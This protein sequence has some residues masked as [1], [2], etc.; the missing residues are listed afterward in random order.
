MSL[1]NGPGE[2]GVVDS[3]SDGSGPQRP[4]V[5]A[6]DHAAEVAPTTRGAALNR[7]KRHGR[8]RWRLTAAL[9]IA[10]VAVAALTVVVASRNDIPSRTEVLGVD[11]GGLSESAAER[12]L[13]ERLA[14]RLDAAVPVRV[15]SAT[16]TIKPTD[17]GL[18]LD[19]EAT[20]DAAAGTRW[21]SLTGLFR[22]RDVAPVVRVD[23]DKLHTA[24]QRHV[25][26][27]GVSWTPPAI[28]YQDLTPVPVY[29]APGRG[30]DR[31][32]AAQTLR[33]A[34]LRRDVIDFSIVQVAPATDRSQVDQLINE[35]AGPAVSAPVLLAVGGKEIEITPSAIAQ[36]LQFESDESGRINPQFVDT[37]LRQS[38][39]GA[40][41]GVETPA[42][43]ATITLQ[44][45][46][47][48]VTPHVDGQAV[49]MAKLSADLLG[50]VRLPAPRRVTANV[51]PSAPAITTEAASGFGVKEK[52]SSFTTNFTAGQ[53]RNTNIKK[54]A[55]IVRGTLVKAGET[56]SLNAATGERTIAKGYVP[57]P[58]I[59]GSGKLKNAAGGG[60]SQFATTI[61]NAAYYAGLE[62]VEH[63]PHT[64]YFSRY[65]SVIEATTVYPSLDL[66]F[67]NDSPHAVLID[68]SYTATSLTVS[69]WSTK[70]YDIE[71]VY[72]PRT[73]VVAPNTVYL[74]EE[75]C[76][77]TAGIP[78][79]AQEAWRVFKQNG[80]EIKRQ[81]FFWRY[82]AEPRFVCGPPP[83]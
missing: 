18:V 50:A 29:P 7:I 81:R 19:V 63:R 60:I 21:T 66:K 25:G 10:V 1:T 59:D 13:A 16:T 67:R 23:A 41:Q 24:L 11:L 37:K 52:I 68:T 28:R 73:N 64:Y 14:G 53:S 44:A 75:D 38:L 48:V 49:D 36:S 27:Q 82:D 32:Q 26:A 39:A 17:V 83:A 78:G 2:A 57:A 46:S 55:D 6:A 54:V 15:G 72:G 9:A 3:C 30:V 22:T 34:W 61:F 70:R 8:R 69:L 74:Q 43:N 65:P 33:G 20:V 56:F 51:V 79:F 35:L 47:P 80:Q 58:V 12:R 4:D 31:A 76:N 45:G 71:T 42:R 40:L 62:D 5:A 77:A